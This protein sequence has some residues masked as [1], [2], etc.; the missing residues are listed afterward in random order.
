MSHFEQHI[1]SDAPRPGV[2]SRDG[3]AAALVQVEPAGSAD[4]HRCDA[5][6][7]GVA[8]AVVIER[9]YRIDD[10]RAVRVDRIKGEHQ[11]AFLV[12]RVDGID[13]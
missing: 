8:D 11:F 5:F 1:S 9:Q 10:L 7:A 3:I 6:A 13:H 4:V 12:G 2:W